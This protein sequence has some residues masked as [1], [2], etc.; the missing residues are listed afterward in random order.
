[1]PT[2]ALHPP[3]AAVVSDRASEHRYEIA[4]DG[5]GARLYALPIAAGIDRLH[6]YRGRRTPTR[7]RAWDQADRGRPRRRALARA[8]RL[9]V[10]PIREGLHRAPSRVR[11]SRPRAM[12]R[13]VRSLKRYVGQRSASPSIRS[14]ACMPRSACV[15]CRRSSMC[16]GVRGSRRTARRPSRSVRLCSGVP[17]GAAL[18]QRQ[19]SRRRSRS[20]RRRSPRV[21]TVRSG[22]TGIS[23]WRRRRASC[24]RSEPRC[25]TAARRRMRRSATAPGPCTG[26]H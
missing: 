6:P 5:E 24:A 26:W 23:R 16:G 18:R 7:A 17:R 3:N 25:V 15:G 22:F 1:M 10:L 8:R 11:R 9:T 20:G 21:R 4:I 12:S 14:A 19:S 13:G 2:H